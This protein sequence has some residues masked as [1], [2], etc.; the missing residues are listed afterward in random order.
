M[1]WP[2]K[3]PASCV[4]ARRGEKAGMGALQALGILRPDFGGPN[5]AADWGGR[6]KHWRA[7]ARVRRALARIRHG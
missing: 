5:S 1:L 4:E 2:S 6:A 7:M 3:G